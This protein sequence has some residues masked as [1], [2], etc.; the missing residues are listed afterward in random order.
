MT[1]QVEDAFEKN[2]IDVVA[3]KLTGMQAS[4]RLLQHSA[5]Y[6]VERTGGGM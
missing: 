5:D 3:E 1:Y 4:L 6:Q 2:E